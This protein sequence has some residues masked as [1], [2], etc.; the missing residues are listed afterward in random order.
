MARRQAGAFTL[1]QALAAGHSPGSVR[2]RLDRGIW[3]V[4][5]PRVYCAGTAKRT[6]E[7][8]A[9]AGLL[10]A[11]EGARFS[12]DTAA[13]LLGV[14]L[15][16]GNDDVWVT[17]RHGRRLNW[18]PGL[19][20]RQSTRLPEP[21]LAHG[22]R[23]MPLA[24]TIVDLAQVSE[25]ARLRG[26]LYDVV[27]RQLLGA[28]DVL[29]VAEGFGGRVGLRT[30]R[31]VVDEF[32]PAFESVLEAEA[33]GHFAAAGIVLQ[34]QYEIWDGWWL[35]ARVDLAD[36]ARWVAVEIDGHAA[37]STK[38]A[39]ERDGRRDRRLTRLGWRVLHFRASDVRSNPA[40]MVAEVRA[41][42]ERI[43]SERATH[44]RRPA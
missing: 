26:V 29:R 37:H 13:R 24:R 6:S 30:L 16:G 1:A 18:R 33:G 17:V 11:G 42:Q 4:I 14:D 22:L 10:Y 38:A 28:D 44:R 12:H 40:A 8:R 19:Q 9:M 7:L 31:I 23:V 15:R 34:P 39:I 43:D 25:A 2:D 5:H 36:E 32:D 21:V 35:V 20:V 27:R 41:L 3:A